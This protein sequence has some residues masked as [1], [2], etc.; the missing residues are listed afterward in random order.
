MQ[1][2]TETNVEVIINDLW[3]NIFCFLTVPLT[4][5]STNNRINNQ[6]KFYCQLLCTDIETSNFIPDNRNWK[7]FYKILVDL[8]YVM[9]GQASPNC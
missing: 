6:W 1:N 2:K 3:I 7:D 9:I 4:N 5:D 8:S